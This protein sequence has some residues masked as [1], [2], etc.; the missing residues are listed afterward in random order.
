MPSGVIKEARLELGDVGDPLA[1]RRPGG[2][3]IR[4]G[5]GGDM[6]EMSTFVGIVGGDHPDIN[7]VAGVGV[8]LGTI[9]AEDKKL[10][11][12]G[13]GRLGIVEVAEGDL[14]KASGR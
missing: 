6:G 9:A 8:R 13:P 7:V 11:V 3:R 4:T 1:V 5:I 2:G 14:R 10:A 12:R